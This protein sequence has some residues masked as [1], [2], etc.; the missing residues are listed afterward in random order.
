[1]LVV[2]AHA[3]LRLVDER[4]RR[5]IARGLL[6]KEVV[7]RLSASIEKPPNRKKPKR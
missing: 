6:N 5:L 4:A 2:S 1:L 3:R 7:E